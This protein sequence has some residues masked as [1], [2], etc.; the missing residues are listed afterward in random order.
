MKAIIKYCFF[1]TISIQIFAQDYTL[2]ELIRINNGNLDKFENMAF[3]KRYEFY[4]TINGEILNTVVYRKFIGQNAK[5]VTK[6]ICNESTDCNSATFQTYNI[7]DVN[8]TKLKAKEMSFRYI[9]KYYFKKEDFTITIYHSNEYALT[10]GQQRENRT[11]FYDISISK[12]KDLKFYNTQ[13]L[14]LE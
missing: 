7:D 9:G 10:I 4:K 11:T 3:S 14:K 5:F 13:G 8:Y 1:L 2:P 12:D 6:N